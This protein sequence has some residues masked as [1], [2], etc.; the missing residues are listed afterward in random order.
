[1]ETGIYIGQQAAAWILVGTT[2][3]SMVGPKSIQGFGVQLDL[4]LR[5]VLG[6]V[7][8]LVGLVS[9]HDGHARNLGGFVC[10]KVF[11]DAIDHRSVINKVVV[12]AGFLRDITPLSTMESVP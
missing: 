2:I 4:C 6:L 12:L 3:C 8:Y 1:M 10:I 9:G 5:R 11:S 7:D